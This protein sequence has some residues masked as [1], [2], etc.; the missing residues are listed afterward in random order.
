M[1][2]VDRF[3]KET[4]EVHSKEAKHILHCVQGTREF[5]I[6]YYASAQLDLVSFTN[7]DWVGDSTDIKSTSRFVFMLGSGPT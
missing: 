6:H 5:G 7:S 4:H 1:S 2:V 3:M